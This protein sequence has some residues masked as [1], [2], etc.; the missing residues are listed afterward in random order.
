M[1]DEG[2]R[3]HGQID[4]DRFDT[5]LDRLE[6][7]HL[8]DPKLK[9]RLG[10][11]SDRPWNWGE[12][13]SAVTP[14]ME[15]YLAK[16][17]NIRRV[18]YDRYEAELDRLTRRIPDLEERKAKREEARPWEQKRIDELVELAG[19]SQLWCTAFSVRQ[20][21]GQSL[22]A[23]NMRTDA[24]HH[25]VIFH[26]GEAIMFSGRSDEIV[27]RLPAPEQRADSGMP[28]SQPARPPG[29]T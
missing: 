14:L 5:L 1:V 9:S 11:V 19:Q 12:R 25:Q 29:P 15:R 18:P 20:H 8:T 17:K 28:S 26:D 27:A 4:F 13:W 2:Y 10:V 24:G 21:E 23:W 3:E 7:E 6:E 16:L 22:W